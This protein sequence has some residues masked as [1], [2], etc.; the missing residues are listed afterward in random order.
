MSRFTTEP[1]SFQFYEDVERRKI[2][3]VTEEEHRTLQF[4]LDFP[5]DKFLQTYDF[6]LDYSVSRLPAVMGE[7][8][9]SIKGAMILGEL[10]P[11]VRH[12][13]RAKPETYIRRRDNKVCFRDPWHDGMSWEQWIS[14]EQVHREYMELVAR[15]KEQQAKREQEETEHKFKK[16]INEAA[17]EWGSRNHRRSNPVITD[18]GLV[19][20]GD[21]ELPKKDDEQS[22][23][24]WLDD[25]LG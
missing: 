19:N 10:K 5:E 22:L 18:G 15:R 2:V 6:F 16:A 17:K 12:D 1:G 24:D 7:I 9:S 8:C 23:G 13:S 11:G 3:L 21:V 4:P 25:F 20:T 14:D